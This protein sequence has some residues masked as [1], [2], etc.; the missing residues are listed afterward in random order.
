MDDLKKTLERDYGADGQFSHMDGA[1][2]SMAIKQYTYEVCPYSN[3]AQKEGSG[4][5]SLG[6]WD[7]LVRSD[8][9]AYTMKFARGQSCWQ[10]PQ[11]SLT[12]HL[13]CGAEDKP[14]AVEEPSKCVY[15]MVMETPAVCNLEHAQALRMNL[16]GGGQE[17]EEEEEGQH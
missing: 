11:R 8:D 5:T 6:Q 13:R 10:G 2:F 15:E 16:E 1:C 7:G 17:E 3:A 9:G 14:I 12:V 4:S